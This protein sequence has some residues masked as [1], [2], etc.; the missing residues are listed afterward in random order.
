MARVWRDNMVE[1]GATVKNR[2]AQQMANT[3][4]PI[5]QPTAPVLLQDMSGAPSTVPTDR[6]MAVRPRLLRF[7]RSQGVASDAIEDVVQE[8][9]MEAWR[10]LDNL[11][12]PGGFDAWLNA[13]CRNVCRRYARATGLRTQRQS[14]LPGISSGAYMER[15]ED[16]TDLD[17]LDPFAFD[18]VQE[19]E[20]QDLETLL[21]RAL[22]HLSANARQAVNLCYLMELPQQEVA[23]R[24]GLTIRA[25]ETRLHRARKQLRRVLAG[26]LRAEAET[27]GLAL[28]DSMAAGWRETRL[29][30]WSCGRRRMEGRFEPLPGGRVNL[31]MSCPGCLRRFA[32][33]GTVPLN[34]LRS[35]RP[36]HK[37]LTRYLTTYLLQG[38]TSGWQTCIFCGSRQLVRITAPAELGERRGR[39]PGLQGIMSCTTC[40][41]HV[42]SPIGILVQ[43][44][45]EAQ[46]FMER[47]PRWTNQPETLVDYMGG[48]AIRIRL[49][50]VTSAARLTL[51]AHPQTLQILA[52]F[53]D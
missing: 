16:A 23:V 18:P 52:T 34:G 20:R 24:L 36:A 6:W 29:W 51:L 4:H 28:D 30:C 42:N 47:H 13:I 2:P 25:L 26:E 32:T 49:V 15:S 38:A 53:Q 35:F 12:A 33:R 37:R 48:Q 41:E 43:L 14:A 9:L 31:I 7:A 40:G 17:I 45:P 19:L 5:T 46:R 27:Y 3:Y 21:D 50:D 8:T 44:H 39:W 22:G 11:T 1:R 10:H